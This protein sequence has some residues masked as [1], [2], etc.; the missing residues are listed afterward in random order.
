MKQQGMP[1]EAKTLEAILRETLRRHDQRIDLTEFGIGENAEQ[2]PMMPP[3][4]PSPGQAAMSAA[5]PMPDAGAM[6][7][8]EAMPPMPMPAPT[9]AGVPL[10][11]VMLD[12]GRVLAD[13]QAKITD[14][15]GQFAQVQSQAG[16]TNAQSLAGSSEAMSTISEQV[17]Q[18]LQVVSMQQ[19]QTA[20]LIQAIQESTRIAAAPKIP[21]YGPNGKITAVVPNLN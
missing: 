6:P 13:G 4:L 15:L 14:V 8:P 2:L 18:M 7:P 12:F 11:A 5:P 21:M 9:D 16:Q 19:E 10:Q 3:M 1:Q 20:Q 17:M